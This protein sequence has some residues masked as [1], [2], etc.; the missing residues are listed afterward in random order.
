[1]SHQYTKV[2]ESFGRCLLK[3]DLFQHFYAHFSQS[4]SD[5]SQKFRNTDFDKQKRLLQDGINLAIMF[6][7]GNPVGRNG[8][9]RIAESHGKLGLDI[10]PHLYSYWLESFIDALAEFDPEFCLDIED[11]WREVLSKAIEFIKARYTKKHQALP[12]PF[13]QTINSIPEPV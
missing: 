13:S 5:V 2:R 3:G 12:T 8:I 7:E 11:E 4:H 6:A 10:N 1:M 9:E